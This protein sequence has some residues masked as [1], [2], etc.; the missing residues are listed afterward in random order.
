MLARGRNGRHAP[1]LP[2]F[3]P[4]LVSLFLCSLLGGWLLFV[5][6][7]RLKGAH[8]NWVYPLIGSARDVD[9][10]DV[11]RTTVTTAGL[12]AGVFAIVYAYRKQ[13]V[14]EA[15]SQRADAEALATRYQ[16]AAQQLGDDKAAVRLAGI[17]ALA[18]LADDWLEQRQTCVDVL[19]AYYR[20]HQNADDEEWHVKTSL[21]SII[22]SRFIGSGELPGQWSDCYLNLS[23]AEFRDASFSRM[24]F[25]GEVDLS[26][27]TFVGNTSMWFTTW[28]TRVNISDSTIRGYFA[29]EPTIGAGGSLEASRLKIERDARAVVRCGALSSDGWVHLDGSVVSG[30]LEVV[31]RNQETPAGNIMLVGVD[32]TDEAKVILRSAGHPRAAQLI[33]DITA[34]RWTIGAAEISIKQAMVDIDRITWDHHDSID[35]EASITFV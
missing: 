14:D 29:C 9:L 15:E 6:F 34:V 5:G 30:E 24:T 4:T 31:A 13:R 27:S 16:D 8:I 25:N 12:F 7:A 19:C 33:P 17:Y 21:L 22:Q 23:K 3:L 1:R 11:A 32:V 18:R 20:M 35:P 10:F 26:G 2:R 28:N